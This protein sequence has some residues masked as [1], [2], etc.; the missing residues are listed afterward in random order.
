MKQVDCE[1]WEVVKG[2]FIYTHQEGV[3]HSTLR[4]NAGQLLSINETPDLSLCNAH[5]SSIRCWWRW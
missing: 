1:L 5:I 2:P 4:R 3:A